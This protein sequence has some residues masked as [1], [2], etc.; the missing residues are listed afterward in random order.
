[1]ITRRALLVAAVLM[2]AT[3]ALGFSQGALKDTS[4]GA[5]VV[6]SDPGVLV[7]SVESG[8]PA[9]KAGIARGDIIM[10]VNGAAVNTPAD[11]RA[12]VASH[13]TGDAIT[14]KVRHGDADKTVSVS[15]GARDGQAYLGVLLLPDGQGRMG[16]RD[17]MGQNWPWLSSQ[18]AIVSHVASKSPADKAGL[19]QGDVILS[20]DGVSVNA[21]N[22]LSSLIQQKKSGDTIT[23]AVQSSGPQG[24]KSP[25]D[26]KVTLGSS[27]NT[28]GAWL[29]VSYRE[30]SPIAELMKPWDGQGGFQ[31]PSFTMPEAIVPD[32]TAPAI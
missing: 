2:A 20:V 13:K 14:L 17:G 24:D 12:A 25:R 10:D 22:N 32:L 18:G 6:P 4:N 11:T 8:S 19:K 9:E 16:M 26:V 3:A 30:G 5:P 29:G 23:L 28:K 7:I 27:P 15:L 21:D 1:M 31:V